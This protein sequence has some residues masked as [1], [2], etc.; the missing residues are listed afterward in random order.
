LYDVWTNQY[1][2]DGLH[3]NAQSG[4]CDWPQNVGC[5]ASTDGAPVAAPVPVQTTTSAPSTTTTLAPAPVTTTVTV[6]PPAVVNPP[7]PSSSASGN[8]LGNNNIY[9]LFLKP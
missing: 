1:C 6:A 3:W 7:P 5:T 9:Q 2:A 8:K 4:I